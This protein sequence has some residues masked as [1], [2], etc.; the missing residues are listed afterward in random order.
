MF[1]KQTVLRAKC[2]AACCEEQSKRNTVTHLA[3]C[4]W[5][6]ECICQDDVYCE[7]KWRNYLGVFKPGKPHRNDI[8]VKRGGLQRISVSAE[9]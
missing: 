1:I 7:K 8:F 4:S 5:E 6:A 9:V 2:C 3:L